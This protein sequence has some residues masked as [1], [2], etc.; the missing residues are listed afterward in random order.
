METLVNFFATHLSGVISKEGIVFVIS[1][2]PVLELRGGLLAASI[3]NVTYTKAL[4]ICIL[5]NLLPI[6]F[7]LL[8]I[9][10]IVKVLERF[11]LT[12]SIALL[13]KAKVE[14]NRAAIERY[15]FWGL[16]LFVGIPLPGTGAWTGSLVAG[17]LHMEWKKAFPPIV[18]GILLASVIMSVISY[19]ALGFL[20]RGAVG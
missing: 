11:R 5:G 13:L 16:V 17:L 7:V 4:L 20:L 18:V 19:G 9:T 2:M 8:F 14:K 10:H 1:L 12:R 6:P 15:D 3:L